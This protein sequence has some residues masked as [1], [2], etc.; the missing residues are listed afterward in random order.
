M[1]NKSVV[2]PSRD[3][4][5]KLSYKT[6][7]DKSIKQLSLREVDLDIIIKD[8]MDYSHFARSKNMRSS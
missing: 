4:L 6:S 2:L 1:S 3:I 5:D 7:L 8:I